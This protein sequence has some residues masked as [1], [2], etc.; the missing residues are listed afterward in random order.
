MFFEL[1]IN[2]KNYPP[3]WDYIHIYKIELTIISVLMGN[4]K[5]FMKIKREQTFYKYLYKDIIEFLNYKENKYLFSVK[6]NKEALLKDLDVY[7]FKYSKFIL[8]KIKNDNKINFK[9]NKEA[10]LDK[11]K[12]DEKFLEYIKN[13]T[14]RE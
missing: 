2:I 14:S 6:I 12:E 7:L 1:F 10:L 8:F 9:V 13:L 4:E 5:K 3:K 11:M